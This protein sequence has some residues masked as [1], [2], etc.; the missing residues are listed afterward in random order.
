ML[1]PRRITTR[2]L[3]HGLGGRLLF[4]GI[5]T[6]QVLGGF[7][8][9]RPARPGLVGSRR[10]RAALRRLGLG[11]QPAVTGVGRAGSRAALRRLGLGPR[12]RG[13]GSGSYLRRPGSGLPLRGLIGGP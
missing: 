4:G 1:V 3:R 11:S 7:A 10:G 2:L 9:P 5:A 6:G 12:L 13:P 8:T